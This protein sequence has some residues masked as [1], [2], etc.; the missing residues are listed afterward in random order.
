MIFRQF[1]YDDDYELIDDEQT[2]PDESHGFISRS[3]NDPIAK[4]LNKFPKLSE[5]TRPHFRPTEWTTSSIASSTKLPSSTLSSMS[6]SATTF[7]THTPSSTTS[8]SIVF[9]TTVIN[10]EEKQEEET[11]TQSLVTSTSPKISN[12]TIEITD[13]GDN[14]VA[15]NTTTASPSVTVAQIVREQNFSINEIPGQND[16]IDLELV[17]VAHS[18]ETTVREN[19]TLESVG[20]MTTTTTTTNVVSSTESLVERDEEAE[21]LGAAIKTTEEIIVAAS[22]VE[23]QQFRPRPEYRPSSMA[24]SSAS[25]SGQLYQDVAAKEHHEQPVLKLRG[26]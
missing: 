21:L 9:N 24:E 4:R 23:Q 13:G 19:T 16:R 3:F 11:K 6:T 10:V 17:E 12:I 15:N 7:N 20:M 14:V 26:V 18:E 5:Y 22:I 8:S 25:V 2:K 1:Q